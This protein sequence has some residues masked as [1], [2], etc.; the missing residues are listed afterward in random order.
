MPGRD[1]LMSLSKITE[2][3]D[4]VRSRTAQGIR[5]KRQT[6]HNMVTD[7]IKGARPKV[8]IPKV[9]SK[10]NFINVNEDI[11]GS[12]SRPLHVHMEK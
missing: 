10:P 12:K 4:M 2:E 6:S 8:F 5:T 3:R 11:D 1:S 9:V 7:D